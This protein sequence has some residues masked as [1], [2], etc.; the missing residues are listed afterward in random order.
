M[1]K[2]LSVTL[3]LLIL[4]TSV[5]AFSE[6]RARWSHTYQFGDRSVPKVSITIDDWFSAGE[7]LPRFM[8][9]ADKY[10][11]KLTLYPCG[12]NLHVEDRQYWQAALDAGHVIGSHFF[13]H[14]RLTQRTQ[15]QIINDIAKFGK[16]LD[17]TLGYHYEFLTVR[18]P[19]GAGVTGT[20][21]PV[22]GAVHAA[23]YDHIILWDMDN[24]RDLAYALKTI[25]NGSIILLHANKRDLAFMEKLLEGLKDRNYQYVTVHELLNITDRCIYE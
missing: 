1:R 25:Q 16:A 14:Q 22:S 17:E 20:K 7:W 23:G 3:C 15:T 4:C 5:C 10:D 12:F 13:T 2:L 9:L 24:T 21:R 8:E 18:P 6:T 11:V 19:Y